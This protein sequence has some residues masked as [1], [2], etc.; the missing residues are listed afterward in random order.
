MANRKT[1]TQMLAEACGKPFDEV[2]EDS[3][4]TFYLSPDEA[5]EYGLIDKVT[6]EYL[7]SP[8]CGLNAW[9]ICCGVF[10]LTWYIRTYVVPAAVS[11]VFSRACVLYT[12]ISD[13]GHRLAVLWLEI[14]YVAG[15]ELLPL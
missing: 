12:R 8:P 2:L 14:R 5:V 1:A 15:A 3:S 7:P 9:S 6:Y 4:R 13:K 10:S 11:F